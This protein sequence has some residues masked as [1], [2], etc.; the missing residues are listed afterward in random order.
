VLR[1]EPRSVKVGSEVLKRVKSLAMGRVD[2]NP[3]VTSNTIEVER[4][5]VALNLRGCIVLNND[6]ITRRKSHRK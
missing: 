4:K 6:A 5:E 1:K 3:G 2:E